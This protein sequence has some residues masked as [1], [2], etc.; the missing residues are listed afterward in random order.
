MTED[1][2]RRIPI[3]DSFSLSQT[4][5]PVAWGRG[6]WPSVDWHRDGL[7]WVGWEGAR[8][9]WRTVRP[10]AA[11]SLVVVGTAS[12]A[13]DRDWATS[14]FGLD[15]QVPIL[16]DPV[17]RRLQDRYPGLRPW[18]SGSLFEGLISS[19]V[20]QSISVAAAAVTEARLAALFAAPLDLEGRRYW[21]MPRVDQ[22]AEAEP[23]L[24]RTSGVTSRRA[25]AIVVAARAFLDG[26]YPHSGGTPEAIR[27][28]LRR[29]PLVGPWTAE[30]ALVWG[31][32]DGDAYPSGDVAL[33]RAVRRAYALLELD[34]KGMDRLSEG[35]RPARGWA[36]RYLW[37]DLLGVAEPAT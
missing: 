17:V 8:V 28:A 25:E 21:P 16:N 15:Q 26:E 2:A 10:A 33:L 32:G 23:A 24:I 4:C 19:I 27:A 3:D 20:G 31:L 22:L 34:L 37:T 14:V 18:S 5:G 13:A 11:G 12:E 29:L 9:V 1:T 30:S 36:A 35:W 6:R 7:T